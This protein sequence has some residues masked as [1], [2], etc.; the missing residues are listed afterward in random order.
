M[1][2]A[3]RAEL[4]PLPLGLSA[5]LSPAVA[6]DTADEVNP[7]APHLP[8]PPLPPG[9]LSRMLTNK[10]ALNT[11]EGDKELRVRELFILESRPPCNV[12]KK[13]KNCLFCPI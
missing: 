9:L 10:L 8:L 2:S 1:S 7:P 13:K 3:S 4:S 12:E 6:P 5:A 11:T